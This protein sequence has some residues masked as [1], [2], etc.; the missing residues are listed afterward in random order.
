[1]ELHLQ[2]HHWE[3]RS[4][5]WA[6]AVVAGFA[7]GALLMVIEMI[8]STFVQG[9]SPWSLPRMI[10]AMALGPDTIQSSAFSVPVLAVALVI[11]YLLGIAF[12]LVLAVIIAPFRL[13]SSLALT[14]AFG[15]VFGA[16]LYV[17]DF[18]G[19][20]QAFAWFKEARGVGMLAL[21]VVFGMAAAAL[22]LKLERPRA[23]PAP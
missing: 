19:M 1:M 17:V 16:A 3:R 14:L 23:A 10:A 13:D 8:W 6:A 21:H 5:D 12:G 20:V 9:V 22:Y 15:A 2:S 7:A 18:Y 11:H 4:P